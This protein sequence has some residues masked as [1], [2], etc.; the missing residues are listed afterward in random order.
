MHKKII[1]LFIIILLNGLTNTTKLNLLV[2]LPQFAMVL[3]FIVFNKIDKAIFWHFLFFITSF[4]YYGDANTA[5]AGIT[6]TS[7]NYAKLKLIGPVGFSHIIATLLFVRVLRRPL[8]KKNDVFYQFYKFLIYLMITGFGLGFIGFSFSN[9]YNEGLVQYGSYVIIIFIH[10]AILYR[11]NDTVL[12]ERF[13][14]II[15]PLLVLFP[16]STFILSIINPE[17]IGEPAASFYSMLLLPA[18]LNKKKI[19]FILIGLIFLIH[20]S[21]VLG[22]SGKSLVMLL[23]FALFT[24]VL[25]FNKNVKLRLPI[26]S[27][28]IRV[29]SM[30]F[31]FSIPTIILILNQKYGGSSSIVSK[32]YQVRTLGEFILYGGNLQNISS[33]PYIRVTSLLNILY[34][35]LRNPVILLFGKGYGG[36]FNDHFNYFSGLDLY[37]GAFSDRAILS[38]NYYTGHDTMVT[39]PMFNGVIGFYLL[40]KIIIKYFKL[41]R[42]NFIALSVIPFLLLAFY[43]DTLIGVTGV[44]L[45]FVST[46]NTLDLKRM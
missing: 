24:L 31:I 16:I 20:N 32:M 33:S 6:L 43:F 7:Y 30:S 36:Y 39:I 3:Y 1:F 25:S 12:N 4:T 40:I 8:I 27:R 46:H 17:I 35:G 28:I 13:Y 2:S 15:V 38:G 44:L 21:I 34:E 45:L 23:F 22:S 11:M 10:T 18:L 14:E 41:S 29:I 9:Y 37:R 26:R 42:I 5:E 19:A